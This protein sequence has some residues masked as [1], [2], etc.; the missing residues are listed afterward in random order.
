MQ[1]S[2]KLK[3]SDFL[4]S[5]RTKD[6]LTEWRLHNEL[7]IFDTEVSER[8]YGSFIP[9]RTAE[10]P[11]TK[12]NVLGEQSSFVLVLMEPSYLEC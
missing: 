3:I 2:R 12:E 10:N 4:L 6:H 8:K 11:T 7:Y 1:G 9:Q 5:R